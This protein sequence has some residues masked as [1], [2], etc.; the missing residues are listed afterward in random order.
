M[1]NH[2]RFIELYVGDDVSAVVFPAQFFRRRWL[3]MEKKRVAKALE[4]P[5]IEAKF[6]NWLLIGVF[7][8]GGFMWLV[9]EVLPQ[10][11]EVFNAEEWDWIMMFIVLPIWLATG[12]ASFLWMHFLM[13]RKE[14]KADG[15]KSD[16]IIH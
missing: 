1:K 11:W 2:S 15:H 10:I 16:S 9:N 3:E 5:L 12:F 13:N 4:R 7:G 14:K 8:L 6:V